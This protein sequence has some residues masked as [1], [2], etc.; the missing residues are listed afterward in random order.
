MKKRKVWFTPLMKWL[1]RPVGPISE[2]FTAYEP[3]DKPVLWFEYFLF[4]CALGV[5]A[6]AMVTSWMVSCWSPLRQ[7]GLILM[8]LVILVSCFHLLVPPRL[9]AT[10]LF[11][12][13]LNLIGCSLLLS[14]QYCGR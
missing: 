14:S 4:L 7:A 10:R 8:G 5:A 6:L 11:F 13:I 1:L 9:S 2:E 3:K 12:I